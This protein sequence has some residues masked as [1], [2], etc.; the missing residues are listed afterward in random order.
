MQFRRITIFCHANCTCIF[1]LYCCTDWNFLVALCWVTFVIGII[2]LGHG[3]L[4]I[5]QSAKRLC[6]EPRLRKGVVISCFAL[7]FANVLSS[8]RLSPPVVSI[9]ILLKSLKVLFLHRTAPVIKWAFSA[10]LPERIVFIAKHADHYLLVFHLTAW[11]Y[12]FSKRK[13]PTA[14]CLCST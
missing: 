4:P 3:F 14:V 13:M 5:R 2:F 8:C 11:T 9:K 7:C 12:G 6:E 10:W 1:Q